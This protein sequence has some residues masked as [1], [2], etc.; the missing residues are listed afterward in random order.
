MRSARTPKDTSAGTR[1]HFTITC[2]RQKRLLAALL[3]QPVS[4]ERADRICRASNAPDV[5][6]KLRARGVPIQT[7][8]VPCVTHDGNPSFYGRYW[9]DNA[10]KVA[11][12][13]MLEVSL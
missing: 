1:H 5:V 4:R 8:R 6:L 11:A 2:P 3:R 7:E 9:L 12:R 10:G 13:E